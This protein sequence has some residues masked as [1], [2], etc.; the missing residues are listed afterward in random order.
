MALAPLLTTTSNKMAVAFI[1]TGSLE[2][3][4]LKSFRRLPS[5]IV[6]EIAKYLPDSDFGS[7]ALVERATCDAVLPSN[8][9]HWRH[10][11]T[12]LYDLP[13]GKR[14]ASIVSDYKLRKR[15]LSHLV[16]FKLGNSG[17]EKACLRAIK[18]LILE[19]PAAAHPLLSRNIDQLWH[20]M[21]KSNL[22]HD[23]FR[24]P[25]VRTSPGE[26][27]PDMDSSLLGIIRVVF[28]PWTLL[29]AMSD[30]LGYPYSLRQTAYGIEYSQD[31]VLDLIEPHRDQPLVDHNGEIDLNSLCHMT[32]VWKFHLAINDHGPLREMFSNLPY[33]ERPRLH[34]E[35]S[36]VQEDMNMGN[37]WKGALTYP[38]LVDADL[39]SMATVTYNY[40]S[41]DVF[42]TASFTGGNDFLDLKLFRTRRN[43]LPWPE[44]FEK[45]TCGL[46]HN[47]EALANRMGI[48][49]LRPVEAPVDKASRPK[50][51]KV[52]T[53]P[54]SGTKAFHKPL[55]W[56]SMTDAVEQLIDANHDCGLSYL[57]TQAKDNGVPYR[58]LI[59][60]GD[61]RCKD[62]KLR[63]AAGES[64]P[65]IRRDCRTDYEL[66]VL[67]GLPA[68]FGVRGFQRISMVAFK[69]PK[70]G[71]AK[72]GYLDAKE[73]DFRIRMTYEGVVLPGGTAILGYCTRPPGHLNREQQSFPFFFWTVSPEPTEQSDDDN[74]AAADGDGDAADDDGD[75]DG[76]EEE[77]V[78]RVGEDDEF[79]DGQELSAEEL[80]E[81]QDELEW[82]ERV[83]R[84]HKRA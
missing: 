68:Q 50:F 82:A 55:A 4:R 83:E 36:L 12:E 5:E 39:D 46:P 51:T 15:Y 17:E 21:T 54:K 31:H 42:T 38:L 26:A 33:W 58:V 56:R 27:V 64:V 22:L 35:D 66:P 28:F 65:T 14:P 44:V 45:A 23:A 20:F 69:T 25:H 30:V 78:E 80:E 7:F 32:N 79:D 70:T 81:L 1:V 48:P 53:S 13:T 67:H 41:N 49:Q 9:G 72:R 8:A 3:K 6:Q 74:D 52:T 77:E 19:A 16:H 61:K 63:F 75:A 84:A 71:S 40:V 73:E 62:N 60:N 57:S 34:L 10:R 47:L 11:F 24:W 59:G 29:T 76:D 2:A 18:Q 37:M 43:R